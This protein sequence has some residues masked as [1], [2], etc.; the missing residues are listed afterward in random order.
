VEQEEEKDAEVL[1]RGEKI[2]A[3]EISAVVQ[4]VHMAA[5]GMGP[6][7]GEGGGTRRGAEARRREGEE[8][9][10]TSVRYSGDGNDAG[11][12]GGG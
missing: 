2:D 1:G 5:A 3:G 8:N 9:V 7:G 11:R 10:R 6:R 4:E 12:P